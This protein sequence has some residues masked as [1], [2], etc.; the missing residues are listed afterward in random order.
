[1]HPSE[2][3]T[4]YGEL[5]PFALID[6]GEGRDLPCTS[7]RTLLYYLASPAAVK[8]TV[9]SRGAGVATIRV[10]GPVCDDGEKLRVNYRLTKT[11]YDEVL[12]EAER[13]VLFV[14][15]ARFGPS[16]DPAASLSVR[17]VKEAMA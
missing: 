9:V 13:E 15:L 8:A 17:N 11:D 7:P 4:P 3:I 10:E 14:N 2:V 16:R 12:D 5:C 6:L 1:M